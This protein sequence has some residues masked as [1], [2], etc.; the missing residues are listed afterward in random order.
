MKKIIQS[1]LIILIWSGAVFAFDMEKKEIH[2][3]SIEICEYRT[4]N[5]TP[6]LLIWHECLQVIKEEIEKDL[7]GKWSTYDSN[8][9][10]QRVCDFIF[11][12]KYDDPTKME[13]C[14]TKYNNLLNS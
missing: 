12:T 5:S 6:W 8:E 14:R 10:A 7:Y 13:E 2:T 4:N 9:I 1:I 11:T 3:Y